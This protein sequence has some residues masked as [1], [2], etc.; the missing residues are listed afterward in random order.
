MGDRGLISSDDCSVFDQMEREESRVAR[1]QSAGGS[2]TGRLSAPSGSE[3]RRYA[4]I[5][6]HQ[7]GGH[8]LTRSSCIVQHL[9]ELEDRVFS[10]EQ[11]SQDQ[12]SENSALKQ[13]LER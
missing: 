8:V 4:L 6:L 3:R 9:K 2:R 12:S 10:L 13:L 5:R 1:L 7:P 11:Q